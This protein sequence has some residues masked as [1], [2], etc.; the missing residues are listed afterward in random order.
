MEMGSEGM[1]TSTALS[2][3]GKSEP[4]NPLNLREQ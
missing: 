3:L 1:W 2:S 4:C